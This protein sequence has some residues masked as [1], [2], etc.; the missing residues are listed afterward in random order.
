M[1]GEPTR[2]PVTRFLMDKRHFAGGRPT[3]RAFLP[4]H[5]KRTGGYELSVFCTL[6]LPDAGIWAL[7][8]RYV[9]LP[10]GERT[11]FGRADLDAADIPKAAP[12][13]SLAIDNHPERHANILGWPPDKDEQK[14]IATEL[15]AV[16]VLTL[17]Q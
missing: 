9:V 6:G 3:R 7:A 13:L 8:R 17:V 10:G 15:A 2:D 5:N 1:P 12:S 11:L 4:W 14:A 16:A